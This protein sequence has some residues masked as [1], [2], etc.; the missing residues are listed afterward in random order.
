MKRIVT[1]L[2]AL[3]CA[4]T[5]L[6]QKYV[7][8]AVGNSYSEATTDEFKGKRDILS[9]SN[10]EASKQTGSTTEKTVKIP[11]GTEVTL[12]SIGKVFE[13]ESNKKLRAR[14]SYEG[15]IWYMWARDLTFSDNNAA[16]VKDVLDGVNFSPSVYK[17]NYKDESGNDAY[18][19]FNVLDVHSAEGHRLYSFYYP[20]CVLALIAAIYL[21]FLVARIARKSRFIRLTVT[22]IVPL[23]MIAVVAIEGFYIFRLGSDCMWFINPDF[24]PKK[25]CVLRSIPL[26]A[27]FVLQWITIT[28][29][30]PLLPERSGK[31][32]HGFS[33]LAS[34]LIGFIPAV[35]AGFFIAKGIT[36]FDE[37]LASATD[38]A[39]AW[40]ILADSAFL[41]LLIYP[42]IHYSLCIDAGSR[43]KSFMAG[44]A[45][46]LFDV[47]FWIGML[48]LLI[49]IIFAI[50]KLFVAIIAQALLWVVL[51]GFVTSKFGSEV[52]SGGSGGGGGTSQMV[53]K[54]MNGGVH[55]NEVDARAA[56]E[57]IAAS[58]EQ[59]NP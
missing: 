50:I 22:G 26:L 23:L 19:T 39:H 10:Y 30:F 12:K 29:Y 46:A 47:I 7:V 9:Q 58:R 4:M 49:M 16:G 1:I 51:G 41:L 2:I 43:F 42:I 32:L 18:T 40:I 54:D 38:T 36:G 53:W 56:N 6:A 55:T 17:L 34:T 27:T 14:I 15:N 13:G 24:F 37:A 59:N 35:V 28:L 45:T 21:M 52:F 20:F 57:R 3:S 25:T 44:T 5:V 48:L 33:G 8:D 11:N 31:N